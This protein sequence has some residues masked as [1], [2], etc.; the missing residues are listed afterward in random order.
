MPLHHIS[1]TR[2][3][4]ATRCS[5]CLFSC[6]SIT[7]SKRSVTLQEGTTVSRGKGDNI[8]GIISSTVMLRMTLHTKT[9]T[10]AL[11]VPICVAE[12]GKRNTANG[13]AGACP[14]TKMK[15]PGG[16]DGFSVNVGSYRCFY[17]A[18]QVFHRGVEERW[19][20]Y[21]KLRVPLWRRE[22]CG[23]TETVR[24]LIGVVPV[25]EKGRKNALVSEVGGLFASFL[26]VMLPHLENWEAGWKVR[27]TRVAGTRHRQRC[28]SKAK[29]FRSVTAAV[30]WYRNG[31]LMKETQSIVKLYV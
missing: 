18:S 4:Y 13:Q 20:S 19:T 28:A 22:Q 12:P 6:V 10:R 2:L 1:K 23:Q 31:F 30:Y 24:E 16:R 15:T 7:G 14:N 5:C 17:D 11:V 9:H 21:I 8:S 25:C 26:I 3:P 27:M 29:R